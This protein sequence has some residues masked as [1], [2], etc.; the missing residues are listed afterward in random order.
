[1]SS[2]TDEYLLLLIRQYYEQPK[3][4]AEIE[5][6]L[7]S[8]EKIYS[9]LAQFRRAFDLGE[10]S[11]VVEYLIVAG[12]GGGGG[13]AGGGGGGGGVLAGTT[14][15]HAE[16]YP[17]VVGAGGT[18]GSTTGLNAGTAGANGEN[19]TAFGLTAVGGGG[20]GSRGLAEQVQGRV[21][22][23]GGGAG[24]S[25]TNAAGTEGQ[26]YAGGSGAAN[27]GG[28]GGGGSEVGEDPHLEG[29]VGVSG[30]GG[31]GYLSDITGTA[32]RYAGGGGGGI[33]STQPGTAGAGGLGGGGAGGR[34]N[35]ARDAY[36]GTD[37]TGGGGGGGGNDLATVPFQSGANGGS[38][39]VIVRYMGA[40]VA[41]G[42]S[43]SADGDYTVHTFS[44]SGDLTFT[45]DSAAGVNLDVLGRI[46]GLTRAQ[47]GW[48]ADSAY[49]FLLRAKIIK[50][51]AAAVMASDEHI[52]LQQAVAFLTDGWGWITDHRRDMALTVYVPLNVIDEDLAA[53]RAL[54]LFPR[55]QG[56]ELRF[57][58]A[59][60]EGMFGFSNNPQALGFGLG[61]LA[62]KVL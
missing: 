17:I 1:M 27:Y 34:R 26:G 61:L 54:D 38:G 25:A 20:G 14:V 58:R 37:G 3:A 50:N 30:G 46:V 41:T 2:F 31:D 9:W 43:I 18:G 42:G 6:M 48:V 29:S 62:R 49:R 60:W 36:A 4:R 45:V 16:T 57:V 53:A 44:S 56:V 21:G 23:S 24:N 12:G 15:C 11:P 55:P 13:V 59:E 5:A 8:W 22:G 39:I 35:E 32:T 51:S 47:T 33:R 52:S 7:T 19:S 10:P 28:G 40:P